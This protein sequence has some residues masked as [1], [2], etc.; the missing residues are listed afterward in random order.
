LS[1]RTILVFIEYYLPGYKAG[2]PIRA[3]ENVT[4]QLA[5]DAHF[6]ILTSDRDLGDV[7]PYPH[8]RPHR[9]TR[10]SDEADVLYLPP[11]S[12]TWRN[13]GRLCS[14]T[15]HDVVYLNSAFSPR[16]SLLPL[17]LR[18]GARRSSP[19]IIAPRGEFARS[20][21]R[22][23]RG[24]KRAFLTLARAMG[25]YR[26]VTWHAGSVREQDDI[27]AIMGEQAKIC[28]APHIPAPAEPIPRA[29]VKKAPG[30]LSVA[31][32]SRISPIKNLDAALRIVG[33][34]RHRV[35]F[36]I[37]GPIEDA[38]YWAACAELMTRLPPNV[39]ATYRGPVEHAEVRQTLAPYDL[40][41]L[42]SHGES[43][44]YAIAE[45]LSAGCPVLTS[46]Q[47]PWRDLEEHGAGW[48]LPLEDE[49]G[50]LA[51]VEHMASSDGAAVAQMHERAIAYYA[52]RS[53]SPK[54]LELWRTMFAAAA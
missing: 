32:L 5:H 24:K 46:S 30:E 39:R 42:P 49:A 14:A 2:G 51:I 25:L 53:S 10:L 9:W 54:T 17:L 20:A 48:A 21:L 12:Q 44:S 50:F 28:V 6:R 7:N 13:I 31:F 19:V 37:Y 47:T 4:S 36:D 3:I 23:K 15:P 34:V 26:D 16:F 45:A 29:N 43:F 38:R 35:T 40:F 22:H 8:V 27:K 41:F 18:R 33:R 11:E 1:K 52:Q